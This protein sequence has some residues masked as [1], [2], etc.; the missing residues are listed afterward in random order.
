MKAK[1]SIIFLFAFLIFSSLSAQTTTEQ[2]SSVD[3]NRELSIFAQSA[4]IKDYKSAY[5]HYK[6]IVK[7]CPDLHIAVYQYGRRMFSQFIKDAKTDAEKKKYIEAQIQ[8]YNNWLKYFPGKKLTK[9]EALIEIAQLKY[10]A[11]MGN[12]EELYNNFDQA[13]KAGKE[14]FNDPKALYTYFSLLI[15]LNDAGKKNLQEVFK[16]YDQIISKI[17]GEQAKRAKQAEELQAKKDSLNT[18]T[19]TEARILKN[20]GIYLEYY[21]KIIESIDAKIGKRADC[22]NLIPLFTKGFEEHKSD[23]EW[24]KIAAHRLAAKKCTEGDLF[25]KITK[26]L[27]VVEPSA[28]SAKYL[29]VLAERKGN[30]SEAIKFYKQSIELEESALEK[31]KVYYRIGNV[32]KD[33]GSYSAARVN[34]NR[35]LQNNPSLGVAYLKIA[36]MYAASANSCGKDVFHKRAVYWLAEEAAEAAGRV[37][38]S[39]RSLAGKSAAS[40]AGRAPSKADIFKAGTQGK[41]ITIGCW[42]NRKIN[43]PSL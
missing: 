16:K 24:L 5:P 31:A 35:A 25:F 18:L 27:N 9:G 15:D 2:S 42:I 34:Y 10:D 23:A 36:S 30:N 17:N 19:K 22:E 4:K 26:A 7:N 1:N 13:W 8:N 33:Q 32:Y 28:K 11:K 14:T 38:P 20:D 40:Y 39:I 43:V 3:C 37:D 29:G 41:T 12:T 6:K 21:A